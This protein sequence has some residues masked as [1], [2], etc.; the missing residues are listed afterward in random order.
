MVSFVNRTH[1]KRSDRLGRG[2]HLPQRGV[3]IFRPAMFLLSDTARE[4]LVG[5]VPNGRIESVAV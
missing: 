5:W 2:S 1:L 3:G 4:T